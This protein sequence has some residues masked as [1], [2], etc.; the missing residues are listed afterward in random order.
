[1]RYA[2]V[3]VDAPTGVGRLFSYSVPEGMDAFPGQLALVPFGPRVLQGVIFELSESPQ[4]AETRPVSEILLPEP[5]LDAT[6]LELA[7][8]IGERYLC[9]PFEA[10]APLL[11]PGSRAQSRAELSIPDGVEDPESLANGERQARVLREIRRLG[12][13]ADLERLASNLGEWA[14]DA[15]APLVRRGALARRYRAARRMTGPRYDESLSADPDARDE[16]ERWLGD[17]K[18]RAKKQIALA[19]RLLEAQSGIP[20]A[21]ARREFGGAVVSALLKRGFVRVERRRVFRDALAGMRFDP[22]PPVRLSDDQRAAADAVIASMRDPEGA[23][24]RVF[25]LRGVTGSGKTEVYLAAVEECVALGGQAII[26]VPEIAL[27]PQTIR[28]FAAR[29]PGQV[30]A[31]HSGLTDGQRHDQW[32][33]IARGEYKIAVGSRGA[34]FAPFPNPRLIVLDEEHE[35]T[36][37]Q[38]DSQPRYHARDVAIRLGELTGAT[39]LLGSASPDVASGYRALRGDY[40]SSV[41]PDRLRRDE[42]GST[43]VLPLPSVEIIDMRRELRE[44]NVHMFS[45]RLSEELAACLEGGHQAILFLN[46]RGTATNMHC[47]NC[48]YSVTCRGCEVAMTY[49]RPL[50]RLICHYCGRKRRLPENCPRCLSYRLSLYGI[51]SQAVAETAA[52]EYP[53]ARV[54]R[55][56]RDAARYPREYERTLNLFRDRQADILVGTQ[57]LSKGL[58]LPGVTVV[59]AVLA[60]VGLSIPDYR[61]GERTFQLLCQ[62]AGRAGR[63]ADAGRA[64]FQTYQ[65]ENYAIKAASAQNYEA[66]YA[67][68]MRYRRE[69]GNPPHSRL[70]RLVFSHLNAATAET[71]AQELADALTTAR[72]NADMSQVEILGPTPPYPSRLR[73]RYRWHI[74]LRGREPR[75][76]LDMVTIPQGWTVDV[77]PVALT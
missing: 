49:H 42:D 55:W 63:G 38:H 76:L 50:G 70:I 39:T 34:V 19:R 7:R 9:S 16:M 21:D 61:S 47:R 45:R 10:A 22:E 56:D 33:A 13:T 59:G 73:G 30:A 5:V 28:R 66:F 67:A 75:L 48:G 37:K 36:Y 57:M 64:I 40:G 11:P 20:A 72:E 1:M 52:R 43:A 8:W 44:G 23:E 58:H 2:E 53:S 27:T 26:L 77:D 71:R 54:L 31:L 65:P 51:G 24:R 18:N 25:L 4:V 17:G 62:V 15:A 60:D 41:L 46:R 74:V 29:F 14:R 35:W 69:H 3:A 6:R 12:G 32:W 68:E